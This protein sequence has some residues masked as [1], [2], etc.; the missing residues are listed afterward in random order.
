MDDCERL[1]FFATTNITIFWFFDFVFSR[2]Q[3]FA[4][5]YYITKSIIRIQARFCFI[6]ACVLK[7]HNFLN[8]SQHVRVPTNIM[9]NNY[10]MDD[11]GFIICNAVTALPTTLRDLTIYERV[12]INGVRYTRPNSEGL[13][14]SRKDT[15]PAATKTWGFIVYTHSIGTINY[16]VLYTSDNTI[17]VGFRWDN[18]IS[19]WW[20]PSVRNSTETTTW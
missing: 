19:L 11:S 20:Q 9:C 2:P 7:T 1:T 4:V 18:N 5:H 17:R 14:W 6:T 15:L 10:N 12:L 3:L 13:V 16:I 8:L